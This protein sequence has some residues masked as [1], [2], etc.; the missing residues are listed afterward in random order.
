[1]HKDDFSVLM[2]QVIVRENLPGNS[3]A[4]PKKKVQIMVCADFEDSSVPQEKVSNM[5]YCPSNLT[6]LAV[7]SLDAGSHGHVAAIQVVSQGVLGGELAEPSHVSRHARDS[8]RDWHRR[9]K[10]QFKD[11]FVILLFRAIPSS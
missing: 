3:A 9:R 11:A 5:D 2:D 8:K 7:L 6:R 10:A 1:M 4:D